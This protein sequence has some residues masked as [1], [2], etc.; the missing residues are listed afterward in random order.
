[1]TRRDRT[2]QPEKSEAQL[3]S[4][5]CYSD[6]I[7]ESIDTGIIVIDRDFIITFW[8]S[9]MEL[10]THIKRAEVLGKGYFDT[11]PH[12]AHSGFDKIV[13]DVMETGRSR[14]LKRYE[15]ETTRHGR[16][17]I[18]RTI[19][20]F[21]DADERIAGVVIITEDI[22]EKVNLEQQLELSNR[23][24]E[25]K[26]RELKTI[27]EV[28]KAMQA[29]YRLD[30]IFYIVLKGITSQQGLGYDRAILLLLDEEGETLVGQMGVGPVFPGEETPVE[31]TLKSLETPLHEQVW[32]FDS[33]VMDS[34]LNVVVQKIRLPFTKTDSVLVQSM[35]QNNPL[36]FVQNPASE[37]SLAELQ[38]TN[39]AVIPLSSKVGAMG[40][41]AV[42]N[43]ISNMPIEDEDVDS[44]ALLA[45]ETAIAIENSFLYEDLNN[46]LEQLK[47]ANEAIQ[48]TQEE[49][50][51][52]EKLTTLSRM[53]GNLAH[54]IRNPLSIIGGFAKL[55]HKKLA[56]SDPNSE[57]A[58][59]IIE[60]TN[61]LEN[62]IEAKLDLVQ[63]IELVLEPHSLEEV[64]DD[65]IALVQRDSENGKIQFQKA[66]DEKLPRLLID[67]YQMK[68]ALLNI[69][70]NSVQA[71]PEGGELK[72]EA[73]LAGKNGQ[74]EIL[75][76]ITDT[77]RGISPA[78]LP[79]IF[80]PFFTTENMSAGLGLAVA[81]KIISE[82][83][84]SISVESAEGVGTSIGIMLPVED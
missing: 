62:F 47:Q 22:T 74:Q 26:V 55:L 21:R 7:I 42:D 37:D 12:L 15:H 65:T 25:I 56:E 52:A 4:P 31:K 54:E 6:S 36:N 18:N 53:A 30:V 16:L 9:G 45:N 66:I 73:H 1:M 67:R 39:F 49:L 20:P 70:L 69:L 13:L 41:I 59:I 38:M 72:I 14:E 35:L 71:M 3:I 23:R 8:N 11:F 83:G 64:I 81:K 40:V 75:L 50:I 34:P 51:H 46:Q 77:G 29:T 60:K 19:F 79:R 24:L 82:H 78:I 68:H 2:G 10:L 44:L 58:S 61:E 63:K 17:I 48:K 33:K 57:F 28:T 43:I 84:G 27:L 5:S 76:K 32:E 80:D